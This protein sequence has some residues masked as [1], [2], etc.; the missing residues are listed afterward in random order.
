MSLSS[1]HLI[2]CDPGLWASGCF[3]WELPSL[4]QFGE[5][6][7]RFSDELRRTLA[8]N[9]G[10]VLHRRDRRAT[11]G[12]MGNEVL[13]SW[14]VIYFFT[15]VRKKLLKT[16]KVQ[17]Q[18]N[19]VSSSSDWL[20]GV[21]RYNSV[22]LNHPCHSWTTVHI[23]HFLSRAD[24]PSR[25]VASPWPLTFIQHTLSCL[26]LWDLNPLIDWLKPLFIQRKLTVWR[27][28]QIADHFNSF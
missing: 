2:P 25:P 24:L 15:P 23:S 4:S 1:S 3:G 8:P 28:S 26:N 10:P 9:T 18:K 14:L 19:S 17:S 12:I 20:S 13:W 16:F 6:S 5:H 11:P 22:I 7:A 27:P 21:A